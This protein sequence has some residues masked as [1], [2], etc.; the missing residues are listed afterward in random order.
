[1]Q[2]FLTECEQWP[3]GRYNDQVDAA[4]GAFNKLTTSQYDGSYGW[5]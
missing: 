5:V 2:S 1:V 4:A 3:F